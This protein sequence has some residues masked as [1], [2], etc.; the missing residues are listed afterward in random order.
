ME[1]LL[2]T[3]LENLAQKP[4]ILTKYVDDIFCIIREDAIEEILT[5]L[6]GFHRNI[7]FTAEKEFNF[8]LPYLDTI[9]IRENN[10]LKIDWYQK[11]TASGRIINFFSKHPKRIIINTANN[12]IRRVL[13][14]SDEEFHNRNIIKI[15]GILKENQF[16]I[17]LINKLIRDHNTNKNNEKS[18]RISDEPKTYKSLTYVPEL[19]ERFEKS[20][21]FNVQNFQL[22]HKTNNTLASLFSKTKDKIPTMEKSNLIYKIPCTG[23]DTEFCKKVYMCTTKNKLKTRIA[24]HKSDQ[25]LRFNHETQK[26]A[27]MS[28]CVSYKHSPDFDNV[29]ILDTE[30]NYKRRYI[31]EMLNIVNTP[32]TLRMNYKADIECSAASSYRHLV[33]KKKQ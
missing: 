24:A 31:L 32:T 33:T 25:R 29:R 9:V 15:K 13:N 12:L 23:N 10:A 30:N 19:S 28:H 6:N 22:A 4:K 26:T 27:L 8:K 21:L 18:L 2:E 20:K 5:K 11:P 1:K 14:L 7:K 16:P 17:Q 3:S